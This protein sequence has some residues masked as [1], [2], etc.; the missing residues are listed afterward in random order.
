MSAASKLISSMAIQTHKTVQCFRN[1]RRK[2]PQGTKIG[3]VPTMGALHE[4]KSTFEIIIDR[5]YI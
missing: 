3:F 1:A 5:S 4:G 2:I